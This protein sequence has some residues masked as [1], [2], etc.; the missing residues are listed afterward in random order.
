MARFLFIVVLFV[1]VAVSY[2][3]V[4]YAKD[5]YKVFPYKEEPVNTTSLP[6]SDYQTW[7]EFSPSSG[8]FKVLMPTLPQHVADK[9]NDPKQRVLK[10]TK[11]T[12]LRRRMEQST[13]SI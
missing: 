10:N 8:L 4:H 11:S 6:A 2:L 7:I 9:I 5:A 13:L 1:V 12:C 3:A